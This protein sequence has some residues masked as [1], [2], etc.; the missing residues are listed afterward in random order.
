MIRIENRQRDAWK[1]SL[2]SGVFSSFN[3]L[4][5]W[6]HESSDAPPLAP[7]RKEPSNVWDRLQEQLFV[8]ADS[9]HLVFDLGDKTHL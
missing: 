6:A 5:K 9:T 2:A 3:V 1:E 4:H 8:V 7:K